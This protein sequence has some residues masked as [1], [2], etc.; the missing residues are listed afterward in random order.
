MATYRTPGQTSSEKSKEPMHWEDI[1]ETRLVFISW[2]EKIPSS[3]SHLPHPNSLSDSLNEQQSLVV[4]PSSIPSV[5]PYRQREHEEIDRNIHEEELV[6]WGRSL[7]D[8]RM[9]KGE[10]IK[11]QT[12]S[13]TSV[14]WS[15]TWRIRAAM[16][17]NPWQYPI[18]KYLMNT[19]IFQTNWWNRIYLLVISCVSQK[20]SLQS[21]SIL[22]WI[23]S[24]TTSSMYVLNHFLPIW[25]R[26]RN[27]PL[28]SDWWGN[29]P[30]EGVSLRRHSSLSE[31]DNEIRD[32]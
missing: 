28:W 32:L 2:K 21:N 25:E 10:E 20:N 5:Q 3:Y 8:W 23:E 7:S 11:D 19:P 26:V 15:T 14:L 29:G 6:R 12:L 27:E 30:R 9:R 31:W 1:R 24:G 13:A 4:S 18:C 17:L 22:L 16:I